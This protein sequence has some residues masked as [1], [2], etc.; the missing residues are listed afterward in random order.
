MV[1]RESD[2]FSRLFMVELFCL[3]SVIYQFFHR[4]REREKRESEK[5]NWGRKENTFCLSKIPRQQKK[6]KEKRLGF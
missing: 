3:T 1:C 5:K 4:K 2:L 6:Q